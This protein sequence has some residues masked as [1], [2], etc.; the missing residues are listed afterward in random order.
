MTNPDYIRA[1]N[2]SDLSQWVVHFVRST[3]L[4]SPTH[5]GGAAEILDGIFSEWR[6]RPSLHEYVTR[7]CPD[8]AA[9]F[10][11]APP[12][13]WSAIAATN[14]SGRPPIGVICH[15]NKIW[16][17]GGRPVIYTDT[18]DSNVW[19]EQERFR[20]VFTDLRRKPQPIDW[21]H[22]REW[23]VRGGLNLRQP[24]NYTWWWPIVPNR[25]W[26]TYLF[27]RYAE[28]QSIYVISENAVT[29]RSVT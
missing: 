6:I 14:P 26:M 28:L 5:L 22:E 15:K 4:V 29:N 25:E 8:G 9:C 12:S 3:T 16:E 24:S 13:V 17:L 20:C 23:R 18:F 11:D 10:Y 19:P 27:A 21:T 7:Y 1:L 2:R